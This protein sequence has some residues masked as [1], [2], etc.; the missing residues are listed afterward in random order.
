MLIG[1]EFS[2]FFLV[3]QNNCSLSS[4]L[5]FSY[6]G[7]FVCV[8]VHECE[9]RHVCANVF[10]GS[11]MDEIRGLDGAR[12]GKRVKWR[13]RGKPGWNGRVIG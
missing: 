2:L 11:R 9:G 8:S 10:M 6:E 7:Q 12:Q 13:D 5:S 1:E 4:Y 3:I